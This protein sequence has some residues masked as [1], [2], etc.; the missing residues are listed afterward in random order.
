M[1]LEAY[2]NIL[3]R[4]NPVQPQGEGAVQVK[5]QPFTTDIETYGKAIASSILEKSKYTNGIG[6]DIKVDRFNFS[7]ALATKIEFKSGSFALIYKGNSPARIAPFTWSL[8]QETRRMWAIFTFN[9]FY[10]HKN[11]MAPWKRI[12]TNIVLTPFDNSQNMVDSYPGGYLIKV[13]EKTLFQM[14]I[15][16]QDTALAE[17]MR[18]DNKNFISAALTL[19][20]DFQAYTKAKT[21]MTL[22]L[23]IIGI[24]V[25]IIG[26]IYF[27]PQISGMLGGIFPT[28]IR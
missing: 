2:V 9:N 12:R 23:A 10:G 7:D 24:V 25:L 3:T 6:Q 20:M 11:P 19:W 27:W 28:A 22:I 5:P 26:I 17:K 15:G 16:V 21:N 13:D 14:P 1:G 4:L 8:D 18:I